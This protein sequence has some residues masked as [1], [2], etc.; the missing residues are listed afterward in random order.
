MDF[1]LYVLPESFVTLITP[2]HDCRRLLLRLRGNALGWLLLRVFCDI[3]FVRHLVIL[4]QVFGHLIMIKQNHT[5][6]EST[7]VT[8]D[9]PA[10]L[11]AS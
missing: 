8:C 4:F 1:Q 3:Q 7:P 10:R 5:L 2:Y 6:A 9:I 11:S